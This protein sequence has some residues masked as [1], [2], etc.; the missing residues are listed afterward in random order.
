MI[1]KDELSSF[2]VEVLRKSGFAGRGRTLRVFGED[3]QWVAQVEKV[4]HVDQVN[5]ELGLVFRPAP[6]MKRNDCRVLWSLSDF[7]GA[8]SDE[9]ARALLGSADYT[10][11]EREQLVGDAITTMSAYVNAHAT[12]ASIRDAYERGELDKAFLFKDAREL[13]ETR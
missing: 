6:P 8:E 5:V 2:A 11:G 9:V 3:L 12:I 4:G 13:L 7:A 1:M 10:M